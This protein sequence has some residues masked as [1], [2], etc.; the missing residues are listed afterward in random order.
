[1]PEGN[2][3]IA[4]DEFICNRLRARYVLI[5]LEASSRLMENEFNLV[6]PHLKGGVAN[7]RRLTIQPTS[8]PDWLHVELRFMD[9]SENQMCVKASTYELKEMVEKVVPIQRL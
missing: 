7:L 6:V 5:A 9:G 2:P 8:N 3:S 4:R 1:M